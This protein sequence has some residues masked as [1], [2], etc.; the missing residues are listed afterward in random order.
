MRNLDSPNILKI[1]DEDKTTDCQHLI[2]EYCNKGDL[3]KYIE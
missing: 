2:I 3:T 1:Y